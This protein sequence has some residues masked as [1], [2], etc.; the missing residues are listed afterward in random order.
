MLF[1]QKSIWFANDNG[2]FRIMRDEAARTLIKVFALARFNFGLLIIILL[3]VINGINSHVFRMI[4]LY[5]I[6]HLFTQN[7]VRSL[8]RGH[9][10]TFLSF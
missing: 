6:S 7:V 3:T 10:V 5:I 2:V 8:Y 9:V 4:V 1:A